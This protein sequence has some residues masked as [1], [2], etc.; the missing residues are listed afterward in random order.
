MG[1]C[2]GRVL[3]VFVV[4]LGHLFELVLSVTVICVFVFVSVA[5][6]AVLPQAM[7]F[8][9]GALGLGA[10]SLDVLEDR[11]LNLVAHAQQLAPR[12]D[13]GAAAPAVE[14]LFDGDIASPQERAEGFAE[15]GR[16]RGRGR[17]DRGTHRGQGRGV[18]AA[19]WGRGL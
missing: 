16:G 1:A 3:S 2:G 11:L 10:A 17:L 4:L 12:G 5:R 14:D 13:L 19:W 7:Q 6:R 8:A 9:E 15:V 18:P